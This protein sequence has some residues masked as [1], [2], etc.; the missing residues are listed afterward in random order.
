MNQI[1]FSGFDKE[2]ENHHKK[3]RFFKTQLILSMVIVLSMVIYYF[4]LKL[5]ISEKEK[6]SENLVSNYN[7]G[8]LYSKDEDETSNV[9]ADASTSTFVI[10]MIEIKKI[11]VMYPILSKVTDELLEIA[12]CKFYGPNP[13]EVGNLCI[14]GHNTND[15]RFFSKI[16]SLIRGD[17]ISVYD[18]D[19]NKQD[20]QV[21]SYYS[22]KPDDVS[23]TSQDTNN[24]KIITLITCTNINSDRYIV[25]AEAI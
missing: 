3:H 6:L 7:I 12:P 10:G 25:V 22:V 15:S 14:A 21:S 24:R 13:N 20:Y 11:N 16:P 4:F 17:V 2:K 1:L 5:N 19:G 18:G 9:S 23:I 8:L